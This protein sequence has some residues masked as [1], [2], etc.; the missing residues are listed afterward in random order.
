MP[1]QTCPIKKRKKLIFFILFL[2]VL[3]VGGYAYYNRPKAS[4]YEYEIAKKTDIK[5]IVSVTG[6]VKAAK[7]VDLAFETGGKI[8]KIYVDVGDKVKT[9]DKIMSLNSDDL[10]AQLRQAQ[11]SVSSAQATLKQLEA[12]VRSQQAR[13]D[14]LKAGIRPEEIQVA[15]TAVNNANNALRDAKAT[16]EDTKARAESDLNQVYSDTINSLQRAVSTAKSALLTMTDIQYAHYN[17]ADTD[18]ISLVNA[19]ANAIYALFD[20]QQGG[21]YTAQYVSTLNSGLFNTIQQMVISPD[22]TKTEELLIKTSLAL[23]TINQALWAVPIKSDLTATEKID[24]DTQKSNVDSEIRTLSSKQQSISAQKVINNNNISSAEIAVNT[25]K[26][27]LDSANSNLKLKKAG[28]SS[29]QIK[30]QQAQVEQA[31]ANLM[32]QK[33]LIGQAYA[34]AQYYVTQIEKTEL[35]APIPGVITRREYKVGE[36]VFPTSSILEAQKPVVTIM[37]ENDFE[38]ETNIAEVDIA[39]VKINDPATVTLDAYGNN[40]EFKAHVIEIY[41][42]ETLI[43]GVPTYKTKLAFSEQ[44]E[45]IKSGMTANIDILTAESKGAIAIPQRAVISSDGNKTVR[46]LIET[47]DPKNPE[48]IIQTLKEVS[49]KTGITGYDGWVEILEGVKEGDKVVVRII[50]QK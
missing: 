48:K 1:K 37:S 3:I 49:V 30:A 31:K 10:K 15:Q 39:K 29:D 42:A 32:S 26:N 47:P 6:K 7:S 8:E 19:K 16:L 13:L 40:V 35:K 9:G 24:L 50:E 44:S 18:S 45:K 5:Q 2:V 43:E 46:I 41:P 23:G 22:Y 21:R 25:A 14:E 34:N 20:V 36:I 33:A 17:G 12:S 28:Y 11:A 4:P 38:I 27:T